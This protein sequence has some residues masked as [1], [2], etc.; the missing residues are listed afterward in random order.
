MIPVVTKGG[1]YVD[2]NVAN[3][4]KGC[5]CKAP[6]FYLCYSDVNQ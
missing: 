2:D 4:G 3:A 5:K 1:G 6:I